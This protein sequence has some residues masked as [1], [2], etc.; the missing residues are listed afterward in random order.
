MKNIKWLN[1][2]NK[3]EWWWCFGGQD[4]DAS[5][6]ADHLLAVKVEFYP[7]DE[8]G[9]V[10]IGDGSEFVGYTGKYNGDVS[11]KWLGPIEE[12]ITI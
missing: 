10:I 11:G 7:G 6:K 3:S 2:P 8:V 4:R 9:T 1:E 12:P 5:G